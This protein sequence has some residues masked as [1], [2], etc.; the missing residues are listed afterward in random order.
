MNS[1]DLAKRFR[2]YVLLVALVAGG[3]WS[4][5]T[6]AARPLSEAD[7]ESGMTDSM[8]P[9]P[10]GSQMVVTASGYDFDKGKTSIELPV[11]TKSIDITNT[12]GTIDIK[13]GSTAKLEVLTSVTVE[14][15]SKQEAQAIADSV[16]LSISKGDVLRVKVD[17]K[18]KNKPQS[19]S[20]SV[21]LSVN[22]PAGSTSGVK[23]E[24]T[25]GNLSLSNIESAG[26]IELTATNGNISAKDIARNLSLYSVNGN[27]SVDK[28]GRSV[29]AVVT[30]GNIQA[31]GISGPLDLET[32]NGNLLVKD[33]ASSIKAAVSA[34]H[35]QIE[36]FKVGGNWE[37]SSK[38]GGASLSWPKRA[39]VIVEGKSALGG[40]QTDYT[41][42]VK[43]GS[44]SGTIG[45]GTYHIQAEVLSNL[46]LMKR[47]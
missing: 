47:Q 10:S 25:N 28:A 15:A 46:S 36:S 45:K 20:V 43:N 39:D 33:A 6:A 21:H 35:I 38:V 32:T 34:G 1:Q 14:D 5:G 8:T 37:I 26:T 3:A 27:I 16:Q 42:N 17:E 40:I 30:N 13:Q 18:S 24:V 12:N 7:F 29:Q 23:A 4:A 44:V 19:Y 11:R 22:L 41:L 9:T 2:V 31:S